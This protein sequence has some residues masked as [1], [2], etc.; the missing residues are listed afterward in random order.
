MKYLFTLTLFLG[1]FSPLLAQHT[2]LRPA[3]Q[4][5]C[6]QLAQNGRVESSHISYSGRPSDQWERYERLRKAATTSELIQLTH[7]PSPA[8][9]VYSCYALME[10]SP[11]SFLQCI[12]Q[13]EKDSSEVHTM[14]GCIISISPLIVLLQEKAYDDWVLGKRFELTEEWANYFKEAHLRNLD[15]Y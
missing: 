8:V 2:P 14:S 7:Y 4:S 11:E 5:I 10:K 13:M 6:E 1:G 3:V 9:K 15:Q 12:A